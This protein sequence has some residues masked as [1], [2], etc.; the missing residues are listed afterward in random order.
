MGWI[1]YWLNWAAS[2][3]P[4]GCPFVAAATEFDDREGPVRDKL[5]SQQQELLGVFARAAY[6]AIEEG[7]LKADLEPDQFAFE[8]W[9]AL[10]GFHHYSRL[11]RRP[12]AH[13]RAVQSVE[14]LIKYSSA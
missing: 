14:N 9:A 4:G 6:V 11:L 10:L 8:L 2:E 5:I 12:D 7:H 1:K 13:R 3:F